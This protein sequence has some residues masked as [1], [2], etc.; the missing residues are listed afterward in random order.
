VIDPVIRASGLRK[1]YG[2][3][4]AVRGIDLA[5]Q[6]GE[7]FAFLGPNGAGK[8][9]TV[10]VLE[11]YRER[12]GGEVSVL[13]S[14]PAAAGRDWRARVGIVLQQSKTH[15]ELSVAETLELFAGYYPRA[16]PVAETIAQVGLEEKA[17]TRVG[18]LSGG[19]QRRLDV[20]MALVGDPELLF[21]DEPTTGF[22]PSARRQ[23]WGVI[24]GLRELGKTIFLTTHYMEE[25]QRLADRVAIVVSGRIVA[26]G[27]PSQLVAADRDAAAIRFRLPAGLSADEL[28]PS[29]AASVGGDGSFT[30]E[31]SDP[32]RALHELTGWALERGLDLEGLEV[33]RPSLEDVYLQLTGD[34]ARANEEAE[35]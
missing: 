34:A 27:T 25:A 1:S 12:T 19:Q 28:P 2:D 24:E 17:D 26:E 29:I 6:P 7:I 4:E 5:V 13:G 32:V 10:E 9:T 35:G 14:D 21:L 18:R 8:T 33:R 31:A 22:D 20:G 11:G 16:L 30:A 3:T 15:P 23:F